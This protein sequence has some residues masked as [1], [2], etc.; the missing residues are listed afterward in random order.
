[1]VTLGSFARR[2]SGAVTGV[3]LLS[4]IIGLRRL[5]ARAERNFETLPPPAVA[6]EEPIRFEEI[7]DRVGLTHHHELYYPN[8]AAGSYLPLMAFP[9]AL[10]VADVDGD[11]Y[12]DVYLVEPKPGLP[13]RMYRNERGL[14][15]VDVAVEVGLADEGRP[16][17][18]SAAVWAD[19]DGD[20]RL[21][22][23][24]ARFGC[25]TLFLRDHDRL[26]FTEHPELAAGYCSNPKA[27][28]VLDYDGDG[29]PDVVFGNY[30]PD[31]DL[32]TYLPMNHLFGQTG[33]NYA[34]GT[35]MLLFGTARG[36]RR[37][38]EGTLSELRRIHAHTQSVGVSDV[39]DD[40]R[41]DLFF[42]N[43]Y[44]FDRL[45]LNRGAA[46]ADVTRQ[47]LPLREHGFSGMNSDFADFDNSGAMSLYVSEIFAPPFSTSKNLLWK[48]RGDHFENVAAASGVGRC[49]WS[50]TGKFADFDDDGNLDLF[51]VNGKARGAKVRARDDDQ[52]SFWFV[53]NTIATLP[54]EVRYDVAYYPSFDHFTLSAFEPS[55]V[56]WNRGGGVFSDV[57]REAGVADL[58]EGQAAA[59][60]D[61]DNDGRV[62]V[63]VANMDGP[64]LL[65]HNVSPHPGRWVGVT[66]V[67]KAGELLPLGT[68]TWLHMPD[69]TRPMRELYPANGYRGQ[70][71]PRLLYGLGALA[72]VPPLEVRWPDGRSELFRGLKPNA[73][74][75]V[76]YGAGESP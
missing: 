65:Y 4:I 48:R 55:C 71:D 1:V 75:E 24:Q 7:A 43:D 60:V 30:Y 61:F 15:F 45:L 8:P 26:H 35:P 57:A 9:P 54:P 47:Y 27:V 62:D 52:R 46:M 28:N 18:D 56:F 53:R 3:V 73:Y 69:D 64:L 23:F 20:G 38:A 21:D 41:P 59:L 16:A 12:M 49:G 5:E 66:L 42:G 37:P 39:D 31:T 13:N 36:L 76:R 10:A 22:L 29:R 32:A 72:D 25:H 50:W 6:R 14:R 58:E 11:G 17:A 40:G 34:G 70:S 19:F 68:R 67:G 51:V 63:V 2:Y 44:T 33:R 74:Q